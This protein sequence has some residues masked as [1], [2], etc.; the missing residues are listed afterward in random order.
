MVRVFKTH[1]EAVQDWCGSVEADVQ[2]Q[3]H[4]KYRAD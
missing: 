2:A 1:V 4:G 3:L